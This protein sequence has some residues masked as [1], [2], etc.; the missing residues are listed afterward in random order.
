MH[1]GVC[2]RAGEDRIVVEG[3]SAAAVGALHV[4]QDDR[5]LSTTTGVGGDDHVAEG[6]AA[7]VDDGQ[8]PR[9]STGIDACSTI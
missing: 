3:D 8:R 2:H 1:P 5:V 7:G 6:I 9:D 4:L